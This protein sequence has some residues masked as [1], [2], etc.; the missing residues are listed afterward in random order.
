MPTK[1]DNIEIMA[2]N[3]TYEVNEELFKS[4]PFAKISRKIRRIT[5]RK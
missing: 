1:S 2:G 4:L 5:E 3:E